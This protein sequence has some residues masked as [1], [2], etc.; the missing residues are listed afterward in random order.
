MPRRNHR[1]I[2]IIPAK[3]TVKSHFG[4]I[5]LSDLYSNLIQFP[6]LSGEALFWASLVSLKLP[7]S[8]PLYSLRYMHSTGS[9]SQPYFSELSERLIPH[10]FL[11]RPR[12]AISGKVHSCFLSCLYRQSSLLSVRSCPLPCSVCLSLCQALNYH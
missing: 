12:D 10:F 1:Q 4:D 3:I 9:S 7:G 6:G 11:D 5:R 2:T 8:S